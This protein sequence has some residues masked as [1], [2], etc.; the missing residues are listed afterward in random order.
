M[1]QLLEDYFKR[2]LS[3]VEEEQLAQWLAAS[4]EGPPRMIKLMEEHYLGLGV[5][6]IEPEWPEGPLPNFFPKS[7]HRLPWYLALV[8]LGLFLAWSGYSGWRWFSKTPVP[9][10]QV[11]ALDSGNPSKTVSAT[12][13]KEKYVEGQTTAK[14]MGK[15]YEELSVV[16]ANPHPGLVTVRV[17]DGQNREIRLLYAGILPVG[18]RTFTWDGKVSDGRLVSPGGY[19][20]EV[21]SGV[22]VM[23]QEVH[24][25]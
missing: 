24:V 8:F 7:G 6:S 25:H 15:S 16:V 23:R 22:K 4:P 20:L 13:P 3:E 2:D 10:S 11:P 17:L 12:K 9:V 14:P 21:T 19:Y 1:T 18:Q 5:S